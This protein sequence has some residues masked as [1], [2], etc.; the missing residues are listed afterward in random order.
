MQKSYLTTLSGTNFKIK[1]RINDVSGAGGGT[2]GREIWYLL[3]ERS[4]LGSEFCL[5]FLTVSWV[6]KDASAPERHPLCN[7]DIPQVRQ[8]GCSDADLHR[9]ETAHPER[10]WGHFSGE[11]LM[12]LW[13]FFSICHF[14]KIQARWAYV[15]PPHFTFGYQLSVLIDF[16]INFFSISFPYSVQLLGHEF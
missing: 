2:E 16:W 3:P 15:I 12:E 5:F 4:I 9:A 8:G 13:K 11:V 1:N 10:I 14:S 7:W 6:C